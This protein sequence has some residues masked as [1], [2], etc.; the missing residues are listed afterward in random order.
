M[1]CGVTP[2][3]TQGAGCWQISLRNTTL[4]WPTTVPRLSSG[5]DPSTFSAI[6]VTAHSPEIPLSWRVA[7]DSMGSDHLPVFIN[8]LGLQRPGVREVSVIH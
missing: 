7:A 3:K 6:D 1:I 2:E 8:I 5:L 4:L